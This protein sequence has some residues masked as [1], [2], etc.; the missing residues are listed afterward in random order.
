[1]N[2]V[3]TQK[4]RSTDKK[5]YQKS[6]YDSDVP[7]ETF[8]CLSP[9]FPKTSRTDLTPTPPFVLAKDVIYGWPNVVRFRFQY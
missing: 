5:I 2:I 9:P 8:P 3:H 1:M 6:S 4:K 7:S